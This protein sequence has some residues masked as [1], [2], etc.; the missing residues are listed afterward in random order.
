MRA[1]S[2]I[3][4]DAVVTGD[5]HCA[6]CDYNLRTIALAGRCPEC[7]RPVRQ[8][9]TAFGEAGGETVEPISRILLYKLF[10]GVPLI[11]IVAGYFVLFVADLVLLNAY[12]KFRKVTMRVL[13]VQRRDVFDR[14][15][16]LSWIGLGLLGVFAAYMAAN[17]GHRL[18]SSR[19]HPA[20]VTALAVA[21]ALLPFIHTA[22]Y[23]DA[24]RR[25][26]SFEPP[27]EPPRLNREAWAKLACGAVIGLPA[28][29]LA[30]VMLEWDASGTPAAVRV[31][32]RLGALLFAALGVWLVGSVERPAA[33]LHSAL[34][35]Q[36]FITGP[37]KSDDKT[38]SPGNAA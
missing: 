16:V 9:L 13:P 38:A 11:P 25:L 30:G 37:A 15:A 31:G 24:C 4:D 28:A 33:A 34:Q 22:V 10:V 29:Y 20:V 18:V 21:V 5:L 7:A 35:W 2:G 36:R 12:F 19:F 26:L 17:I 27:T 3:P 32:W 8:T 23:A 14:A 1:A 6:G